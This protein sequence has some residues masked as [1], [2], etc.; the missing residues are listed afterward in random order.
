MGSK[1]PSYLQTCKQ[2][3][4][5]ASRRSRKPNPE[6]RFLQ[7]A[8]QASNSRLAK[9]N[10]EMRLLQLAGLASVSRPPQLRL[11]MLPRLWT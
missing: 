10:P 6:V 7:L 3:S 9:R 5:R 11:G 4:L 8:G 2:V 1:V